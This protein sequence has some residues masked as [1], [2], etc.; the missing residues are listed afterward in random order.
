MITTE[1]QKVMTVVRSREFPVTNR[2]LRYSRA[3]HRCVKI[4]HLFNA[5]TH[6]HTHIKLGG[7]EIEEE[8]KIVSDDE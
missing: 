5:H 2:L 1:T 7:C 8:E 6:T 4:N 3:T